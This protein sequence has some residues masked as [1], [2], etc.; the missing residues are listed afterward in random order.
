[1][2]KCYEHDKNWLTSNYLPKKFLYFA[3]RAAEQVSNYML[4]QTDNGTWTMPFELV[5]N[6]KPNWHNLV[7]AFSLA[8]A[9]RRCNASGFLATAYSQSIKAIYVGKNKKSNGLL[10]YFPPFKSIILL[11]DYRLDP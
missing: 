8:Y 7:L 1:M 9:K 2:E 5:Y 11:S 3:L 10:S 6:T 4:I